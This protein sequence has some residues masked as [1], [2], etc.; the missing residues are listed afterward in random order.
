MR[1]SPKQEIERLEK[2]EKRLDSEISRVNGMLG[3]ERFMS[4]APEA[5][6][7]EEKEKLTKYTQMKQQ[8]IE[9]L[10]QLR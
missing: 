10:A 9:R 5:K 2:E 3:N 4:K 8:V 1:I 6:I 7:T